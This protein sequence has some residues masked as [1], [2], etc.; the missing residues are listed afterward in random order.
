MQVIARRWRE[1]EEKK[2]VRPSSSSVKETPATAKFAKKSEGKKKASRTVTANIKKT[3]KLEEKNREQAAIIKSLKRKEPS[4]TV[5]M[6]AQLA[7]KKLE[8]QIVDIDLAIEEKK[9]AGFQRRVANTN[10]L[11]LVSA[12]E[13]TQMAKDAVN[14]LNAQREVEAAAGVDVLDLGHEAAGLL[15]ASS[16]KV[17]A[18]TQNTQKRAK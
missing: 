11:G 16:D 14:T 17:A 15:Q 3:D 2:A 18:F 5:S 7:A 4:A 9:R 8:L 10:M 13:T 1:K 12:I 6:E